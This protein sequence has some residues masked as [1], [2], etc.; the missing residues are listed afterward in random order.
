MAFQSVARLIDKECVMEHS[1]YLGGQGAGGD[2]EAGCRV[3]MSPS[4]TCPQ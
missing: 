2:R 3:P 1:T 4:E